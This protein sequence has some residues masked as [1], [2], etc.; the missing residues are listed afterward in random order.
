MF[1]SIKKI[2]ALS[3]ISSY[4]LK[5]HLPSTGDQG[6]PNYLPTMNQFE[7]IFPENC[8]I[9]NIFNPKEAFIIITI[10]ATLESPRI[11]SIE[12]S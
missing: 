11:T 7:E 2:N 1:G 5:W 6:H 9:K 12:G 3:W 4:K 10:K 8:L